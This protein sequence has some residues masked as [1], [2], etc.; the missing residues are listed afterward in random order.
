MRD[1]R[2]LIE[3]HKKKNR[4]CPNCNAE[5]SIVLH[6][7]VTEVFVNELRENKI[8]FYNAGCCSYGDDRDAVFY[9]SVCDQ[10]FDQE[11]K[12]IKLI[13]GPRVIDYN[14]RQE[15]CKVEKVLSKK[16]TINERYYC[17]ACEFLKN[18]N[19]DEYRRAAQLVG[20]SDELIEQ[21]IQKS[22]QIYD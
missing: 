5:L 16:Y 4:K 7:L 21:V 8:P 9:C 14:I 12:T 22:I 2:I 1:K 15:E 3:Y 13:F 19:D 10:T 6:G 18:N 17:E 11:L 20:I